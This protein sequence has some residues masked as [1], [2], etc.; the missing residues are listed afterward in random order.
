MAKMVRGGYPEFQDGLEMCGQPRTDGKKSAR[1]RNNGKTLKTLNTEQSKYKYSLEII[2]KACELAHNKK[3]FKMKESQNIVNALDYLNNIVDKKLNAL[4][5]VK[6]LQNKKKQKK[7][8]LNI[9]IQSC[10]KAYDKG[11]FTMKQSKN[12]MDAIDYLKK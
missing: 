7:Q 9:L 2:S 3:L 4:M 8:S 1:I 11:V 10:E 5:G 6:E 12:I